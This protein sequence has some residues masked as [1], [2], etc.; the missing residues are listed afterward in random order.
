MVINRQYN[1]Q[2]MVKTN[3]RQI[4]GDRMKRYLGTLWM[5]V[6]LFCTC[7]AAVHAA[8][9][10]V[11]STAGTEAAGTEA[12]G[13]EAAGM[14][15]SFPMLGTDLL[16]AEEQ[17]AVIPLQD[18]VQQEQDV[19][20]RDG[21]IHDAG[22]GPAYQGIYTTE[23]LLQIQEQ[24][25]GEIPSHRAVSVSAA[26]EGEAVAWLK[27]L[28]VNRT[29]D[30][31]LTLTYTDQYS[32]AYFRNLLNL[33]MT[34]G[35]HLPASHGDYIKANFIGFRYSAAMG[36]GQ[37]RYTIQF[38]YTSD[39]AQEAQVDQRIP[40]LVAE[41]GL[42][43][44][45]DYDKLRTIH[46]YL[47]NHITYHQD[48]TYTSHSAYSA[49][50]RGYSVCQ[51][52][53]GLF[54]RLCREVGIPCRYITGYAGEAHAWNIVYLDG[55]WYNV[56]VT[57]DDPVG[58]SLRHTYFLKAPA[59]FMDH[60]RDAEYDT[61]EFH[62]T[63]R[64]AVLSYGVGP[65]PKAEQPNLSYQFTGLDGKAVS[66]T[67]TGRP[68]LVI[69]FSTQCYNSQTV[70]KQIAASGLAST[71]AVEILAIAANTS[72]PSQVS[73]CRQSWCPQGN[74]TFAY[75]SGSTASSA[76]WQYAGRVGLSGSVSYPL[77]FMIDGDNKIQYYSTGLTSVEKIEIVYLPILST[78]NT[79]ED[80]AYHPGNWKYDAV[81]Y[82]YE[83]GIMQGI[84]NTRKFDPD[85][86]MTRE[87][88]ATVL[89][90]MA[91]SPAVAWQPVFSDVESGKYYAQ[92]VL[93]AN[94]QGIATGIGGGRFGTGNPVTREQIAKML[95]VYGEKCRYQVSG[96]SG[97][98]G[99]TDAAS[100]SAWA[101]DYVQ[102]AVSAGMISGKPNGDGSYRLDPQGPA[103][104]AECAKMLMKFQQANGAG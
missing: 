104:R 100:V 53:A 67:G 99:F 88:F 37:I 52:Y 14:M 65:E 96:R 22:I 30:C 23:D 32:D 79:F 101:T 18:T 89:Y 9:P 29:T 78:K 44:M 66:T 55:Y 73:A 76:L 83:H 102:W 74:I 43:G 93:W 4:G 26:S 2:Q 86:S 87:M 21:I 31:T 92:P 56:D 11:V 81:Q 5:A 46:D 16:Q 70:L 12:A 24:Q 63:Y 8:V 17:T 20:N 62:N 72:D 13:M 6:I 40:Q 61:A 51:G 95:Y 28:L 42:H 58:G 64:M 7:G 50:I 54:Q 91:K 33:A 75:G 77:I 82:V 38:V 1:S 39:A 84:A 80:V 41:L 19:E 103:T 68:K 98:E 36:G 15:A 3:S 90:R 25:A 69:F 59:D 97:L 71:G 85:S 10:A 49:L 94:S 60:A 48:G 35:T 47:V 27:Q 57:W 45:S 34:E